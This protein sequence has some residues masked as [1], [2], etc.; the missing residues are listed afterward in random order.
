MRVATLV[1]PRRFEIVDEPVPALGPDEV[2]VRVAACGVCASELDIWLGHAVPSTG[3]PWYP[4][5]E[6]S[7]V[8]EALGAEVTGVTVGEPVAAW[9]TTRGFGELVA[10]KAAYCFGAGGVPLELA[11]GEP[12]SCAVNAVDAAGVRLGDDVVIEGAGFMGDLVHQLVAL[13]GVRQVIVTDVRN[14]ALKRAEALGAAVTVNVSRE[15][16]TTVVLEHTAGQGAD[17]TFEVTG[18]QAALD[19]IEKITRIGGTVVIAGYHQGEARH[20]LLGEWNWKGFRLVNG[21]VRDVPTV[22]GGM[23][24]GMRLLTSG[25]VSLEGLVTHRFPLEEIDDAFRTAQEKPEGF[26]KATVTP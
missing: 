12:L 17:V 22:L 11:L 19:P 13:R 8:V 4:G 14:D 21:H 3:Y 15:D 23:R 9:V 26:V 24:T 10:V 2:L 6:V 16:L 20:I 5:H 25:Q 1:E 18:V 7:G